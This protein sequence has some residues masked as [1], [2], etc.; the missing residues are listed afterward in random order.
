MYTA[1]FV[2]MMLGYAFLELYG[3]W[4][5]AQD[6]LIRP[7]LSLY[8]D[9]DSD[10]DDQSAEASRSSSAPPSGTSITMAVTRPAPRSGE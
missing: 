5:V 3:L 4:R 8:S 10:Q 9:L 2:V 6:L 7:P 1:I